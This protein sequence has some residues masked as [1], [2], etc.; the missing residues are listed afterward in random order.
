MIVLM[1]SIWI[2]RM[3]MGARLM[4]MSMGVFDTRF[5]RFVMDMLVMFVMHMLVFVL[6]PLVCM[7]MFVMLCQV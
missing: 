2:V 4:D 7:R 6:Q 3:R 5:D 1:V